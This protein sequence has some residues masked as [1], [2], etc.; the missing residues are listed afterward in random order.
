[1]VRVS[2]IFISRLASAV[3][4]RCRQQKLLGL[5]RPRHAPDTL[6]R[7][8]EGLRSSIQY[9]FAIHMADEAVVE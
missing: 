2:P 9:L 3:R 7:A 6:G 5:G 8:R 4:P 1:M